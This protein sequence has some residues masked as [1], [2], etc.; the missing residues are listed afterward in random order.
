M[1]DPD[2]PSRKNPTAREWHHWLVVNIPGA[3]IEKGQT[4]TEYVGSAT[5]KGTGLHRYILLAYKQPFKLSF[6]ERFISNRDGNRGNFSIKK[7]AYKYKLG[8]PVAGNFYL[9]QYDDSVPAIEKQLGI[10]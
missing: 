8:E 7:F 4:L 9:A 1:V 6:D 2:A 5:P 10:A 3:K